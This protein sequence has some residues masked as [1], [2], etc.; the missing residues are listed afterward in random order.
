VIRGL[1]G[2]RPRLAAPMAGAGAAGAIPATGQRIRSWR[3][4]KPWQQ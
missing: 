4:R 2:H 1:L 3:L